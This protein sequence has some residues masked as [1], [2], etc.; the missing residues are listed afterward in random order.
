MNHNIRNFHV[1]SG[2]VAPLQAVGP[3]PMGDIADQRR[4]P[5]WV[6]PFKFWDG[7]RYWN[8]NNSGFTPE[9]RR[10]LDAWVDAMK[11]QKPIRPRT[12]TKEEFNKI[13]AS[14]GVKK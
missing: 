10:E 1:K 5:Q 12:L 9:K 7:N 4:A 2:Q 11:G 8:R 3:H 6:N 14:L 13:Y